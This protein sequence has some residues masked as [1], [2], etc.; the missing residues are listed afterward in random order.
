MAVT[1]QNT[2]E[3]CRNVTVTFHGLPCHSITIHST[4]LYIY[5]DYAT[6]FTV[7]LSHSFTIYVSTVFYI[8]VIGKGKPIKMNL[9]FAFVL[10]VLHI[11]A[12]VNSLIMVIEI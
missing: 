2:A 9:F 8:F 10:A 7:H 3:F 5:V 11:Y 4:I 12:L 1:S 6:I